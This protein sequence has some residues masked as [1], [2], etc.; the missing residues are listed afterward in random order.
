MFGGHLT[1]LAQVRRPGVGSGEAEMKLGKRAL[2]ITRGHH[3]YFID[4]AV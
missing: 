4:K 2:W 1:Q 3:R